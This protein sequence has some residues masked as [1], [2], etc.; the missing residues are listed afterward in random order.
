MDHVRNCI[1]A[2]LLLLA[3]AV[4][5]IV[6]GAATLFTRLCIAVLYWSGQLGL[7][8]ARA[9]YDF[10]FAESGVRRIVAAFACSLWILACTYAWGSL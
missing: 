8:V 6:V 1:F 3:A 4:L 5:F 10:L 9:P 2:P 7:V